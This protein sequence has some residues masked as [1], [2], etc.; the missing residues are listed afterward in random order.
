[1]GRRSILGPSKRSKGGL[2]MGGSSSTTLD[3]ADTNLA[4]AR[5]QL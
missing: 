1:M 5:R 2:T 4:P 3:Y